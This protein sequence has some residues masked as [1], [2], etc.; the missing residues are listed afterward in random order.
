MELFFWGCICIL[1]YIYF[2]Y[3][4]LMW[5]LSVNSK[6]N[7]KNEV[8]ELPSVVVVIAAFNEENSI[9][10]TVENK[11]SQ[12]YD[13][14]K[15]SVI[16]VS[17]SSTDST[18]K[19]VAELQSKNDRVTLLRQEPRAGKTSALN[20]AKDHITSDIIVFSD[21]NSIYST[22]AISNLVQMFAD[23][24]TGY[25]TGKMVYVN[26]E[27][28]LVGDGCSAYM[29]YENKLREF[30]TKVGSVVGVDGGI[31]AIRTSLF[32]K[33]NADQLPDFVQP[34]WTVRQGFKVKY[35]EKALLK[36]ES[37][38]EG[39]SEFRMRVRVSLR[40]LWALFDM[41]ILFNPFKFGLFSFQLFSHKLLRY[42][43]VVFMIAA[44]VTNIPLASTDSFYQLTLAGQTVFYLLA[45]MG[46]KNPSL[47]NVVFSA[48]Y[49]FCLVNLACIFA[50]YRF[51]RKEKIVTW[52]PREG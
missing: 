47:N 18:D 19:I 17:D 44:L 13:E 51:I 34:L 5:I 38:Y 50:L 32:K 41:R 6:T 39:G 31:D 33:L 24:K 14:T 4:M 26:S 3:P 40:A 9:K 35:C 30:E 48:P 20:W 1:F 10:K 22:S 2:G 15:L 36:E 8:A 37:L 25:V 42:F 16:V 21:A 52:K 28:S 45:Y 11:L 7:T 46:Y 29:K 23:S 43:A 49:Y 27:G 12:N